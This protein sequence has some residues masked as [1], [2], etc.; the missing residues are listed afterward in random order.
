MSEPRPGKPREKC[1]E[2]HVLHREAFSARGGNSGDHR[3]ERLRGGQGGG[4]FG[5]AP[6]MDRDAVSKEDKVL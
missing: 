1:M 4:R 3:G 6:G 5:F 2:R